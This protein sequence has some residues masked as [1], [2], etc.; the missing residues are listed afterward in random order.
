[1]LKRT[2][3][4]VE[5]TRCACHEMQCCDGPRPASHECRK[6]RDFRIFPH[7][8]MKYSSGDTNDHMHLIQCERLL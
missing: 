6:Q 1:M 3:H 5:Y 4:L 7:R 8:A 2:T